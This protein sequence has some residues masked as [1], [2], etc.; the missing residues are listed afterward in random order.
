MTN[1]QA[2][3]QKLH[4]INFGADGIIR[5]KNGGADYCH[6][7][8][9]EYDNTKQCFCTLCDNFSN[10]VISQEYAD[11][12][13]KKETTLPKYR[14][15]NVSHGTHTCDFLQAHG[16]DVSATEGW[17]TKPVMFVMENPSNSAS[18][19]Y[20]DL[21]LEK[22]PT[23]SWYWLSSQCGNNGEYQ[24]PNYLT[25][26]EYGNMV[27]SL[28]NTFKIANGYLTNM[29]KCGVGHDYTDKKGKS[30]YNY[31]TTDKY[32]ENIVQNCIKEKLYKEIN[33][34]RRD[35]E[36]EENVVIFAFSERVYEKLHKYLKPLDKNVEIY[37]LPHPAN[38]LANDYRKYV[39]FGKVMRGLLQQHFYDKELG[40]MPLK[41]DFEEILVA[42][43][44][45]D[46]TE[47][48]TIDVE[49][50]LKKFEKQVGITFIKN[51]RDYRKGIYGY[52]LNYRYKNLKSLDL[53]YMLTDDE[54]K[55]T[56]FNISWVSYNFDSNEI[57]L[58]CNT[59]YRTTQGA[60][61]HATI[62]IDKEHSKYEI[63]NLMT[64]FLTEYL[65]VEQPQLFRKD[66]FLH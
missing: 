31:T 30:A 23:Q 41:P 53:W 39:L 49:N 24:Y 12:I 33:A 45:V 58:Y 7:I 59:K 50:L 17:C 28:M 5:P 46:E 61:K 19:D 13:R 14:F 37:L 47:E 60:T 34:L 4:E 40:V 43:N 18:N 38:R 21:G 29:V 32:N 48:I 36:K 15:T 2:I 55:D 52:K 51:D 25:M 16:L 56:D 8:R 26:G 63:F 54:S 27:Y 22:Q 66:K 57:S 35:E 3:A 10:C 20:A 65:D 1:I 44:K 62:L 11:E 6:T 42:D 9:H 64:Q